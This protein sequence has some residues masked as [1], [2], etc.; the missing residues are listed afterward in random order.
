MT[1]FLKDQ[2]PDKRNRLIDELLEQPSYA[3]WWAVRLSDW[4]GNNEVQMNNYFPARGAASRYWY[5]WIEKRL[6]DNVP[7]DEIVEGL[8][9]AESRLPGESYREYCET[10]SAACRNNDDEVFASRPGVPQYWAR[11]NFRMPE[12]R[13]V[14]F[15]YSFLGIRIQCAQCHKHPFDQWSKEDFDKFAVLFS[16][17]QANSNSVEK[18][19]KETQ[20]ALLAQVTG[21][22][23]I[24]GGDLRKK[25]AEAVKEGQTVPFPELLVISNMRKREPV[26]KVAKVKPAEP[27]KTIKR[28]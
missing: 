14:G 7:Y 20:Q 1:A 21:G 23:E 8:V 15:A 2:S 12:D 9:D 5:A 22:K 11:N 18:E 3:A 24:R 28:R 25:V 16:S 27:P 26:D 13:A 6:A 10:M 17:I 19:S 4:T